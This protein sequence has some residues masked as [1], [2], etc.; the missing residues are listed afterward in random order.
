MQEN[1]TSFYYTPRVP[2]IFLRPSLYYNILL[3]FFLFFFFLVHALTHF[4]F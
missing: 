3:F 2:K 4:L 1:G